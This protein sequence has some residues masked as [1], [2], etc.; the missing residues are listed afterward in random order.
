MSNLQANRMLVGDNLLGSL[1][2]I[3]RILDIP[4]PIARNGAIIYPLP[5]Y[6]KELDLY[7]DPRAPKIEEI[8]LEQAKDVILKE[9]YGEFCFK[10]EQSRTH[11]I[12]RIITPYV[13]GII[14]FQNKVPLWYFDAN[15][16]GAGKD[17]CNGVTQIV[18]QGRAFEDA[19]T[20]ESSEE[21]RKRITAALVSGRRMMYFANCQF[22]LSDPAL[23]TAIT[24]SIFRI[25]MLGS[26]DASSDLELV[27]ELEFSLSAN[28]GLT[29]REDYERRTRKITL[30]YY[31]EHENSS[32]LYHK[33]ITYY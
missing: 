25:R 22:H 6:N 28:I 10:D 19:P 8:S 11:A 2:K 12:A 13:R 15:R 3:T 30:A 7:C 24:D 20:G 26:T 21:T 9:V 5:G 16:A 29:C 18:Y 1:P 17:Y 33:Y 14:G 27:N 23:L 32:A 31:E 4:I